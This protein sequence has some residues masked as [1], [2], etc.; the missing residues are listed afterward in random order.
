MAID[1]QTIEFIGLLLGGA[2]ALFSGLWI[3]YKFAS[4]AVRVLPAVDRLHD[5]FGLSP[6][7]ELH[8][9]ISGTAASVGELEIR[10]RISERHLAIGIYVCRPDGECTWANDFLCEQFG[11]DSQE[12]R[13][14]GWLAAVSR[15][16]RDRV[17]EAW[18]KAVTMH[19][20]YSETYA[21]VP[22]N[23]EETWVAMTESWPVKEGEKI[24]CYVGYVKRLRE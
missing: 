15:H 2:G 8:A 11:L 21:V 13:G 17:L 9:V 12:M 4:R 5:L 14:Y 24:I 10:Q 20:P 22:A 7:D 16:D 23:D 18:T 3:A 6:V 19:L 1:G